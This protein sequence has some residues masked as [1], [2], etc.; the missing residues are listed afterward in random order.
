MWCDNQ[1][2]IALANNL[3]FHA[4]TKHIDLDVHFVR[5]KS[6]ELK[7]SIQYAPSLEQVGYIFT[8]PL[9][10]Q[11]FQNLHNKLHVTSLSYLQGQNISMQD[12]VENGSSTNVSKEHSTFSLK[13]HVK[14]MPAA[15]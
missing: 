15:P 12:K 4:C 5:E 14:G 2:S 1:G 3:V 6:P 13:G 11:R 8:K 7:L 9:L 10:V